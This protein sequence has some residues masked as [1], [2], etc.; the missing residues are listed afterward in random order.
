MLSDPKIPPLVGGLILAEA[1]LT[2]CLNACTP[3]EVFVT[4]SGLGP[5]RPH[6]LP[7]VRGLY[8]AQQTLTARVSRIC[9]LLEDFVLHTTGL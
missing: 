4:R 8:H 2:L 1:N 7:L 3:V 6:I 5:G 9:P